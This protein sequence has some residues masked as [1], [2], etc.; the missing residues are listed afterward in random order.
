[1]SAVLWFVAG[2]MAGATFAVVVM[3]LLV[4]EGQRE[5]RAAAH[6]RERA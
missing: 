1:M 2:A 4:A 3:A 6:R 5:K